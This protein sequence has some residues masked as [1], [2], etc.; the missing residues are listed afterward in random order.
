VFLKIDGEKGADCQPEVQI[1]SGRR[2][3]RVHLNPA[4]RLTGGWVRARG[5]GRS[6]GDRSPNSSAARL[7]DSCCWFS[8]MSKRLR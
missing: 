4:T 2:G 5:C 3:L 7:S 8:V 1:D 6:R